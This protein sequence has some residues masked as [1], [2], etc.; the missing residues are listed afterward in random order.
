VSLD[1]GSFTDAIHLP[2]GTTAQRP[3][4][5]AAGYFRYNS[6]TGGFE[7]YTTEW[8]AIA[9]SGGGASG[10]AVDQNTFTGNGSTTAFTLAEAPTGEDNT[11]VF[12]DGVYQDD[13]TYSV[14]GT[15]LTFS[16]A[17]ANSRVITVYTIT[18]GILGTAPSIDTMTGDGSDTTLTLSISPASENATFVTID[19]VVQH[20]DTYSVSGTTLTFSA[21]PPNG[22][23]VECISF[24]NTTVTTTKLIQ[25][26]D[27]DTKIQVEE[28]SDED[29][30]RFDTGGTERVIIDSTGLG[31]GTSS[32]TTKG[33]FYSSTSMNQ[34]SVDGVGAIETG[35]NFKSGGTTYGQIY[36][37]N[38]SPYDMSVLQQYSTG[39]LIFGTNDTERMRI[40][41]TGRV[42]IGLTSNINH[43]L[44]VG[45]ELVD[46]SDSRRITIRSSNHGANAGYR[47]DAE[48]SNGTARSAGYYFQ[49]GDNDSGTYLGLTATDGSYQM[50][51][52]RESNVGIGAT[53]LADSQHRLKLTAGTGGARCLNMGVGN[54]G[55]CATTNNTSGTASS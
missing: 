14:S 32:P 31:V 26:A 7:G 43:I 44:T 54:G 49:P 30:I 36:F 4:S 8:G 2:V 47:F 45:D 24:A 34:L 53:G 38:V 16:T 12:I 10:S 48:S 55:L 21:A 50:T 51:I 40:M 52:T 9:G 41:S 42:G 22:S 17:P 25:D 1:I 33:H 37:N 27:Q 6:T 5:P 15:T 46:S 39:S 23:A 18:S 29:K 28:S 3:T 11:I 13:S 20:K 19:G 35:I